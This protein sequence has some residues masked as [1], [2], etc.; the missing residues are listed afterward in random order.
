MNEEEKEILKIFKQVKRCINCGEAYGS[1]KVEENGICPHCRSM[2]NN[3][4][5][6]VKTKHRSIAVDRR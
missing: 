1:D 2:A 4:P 5:R 6:R 3:F